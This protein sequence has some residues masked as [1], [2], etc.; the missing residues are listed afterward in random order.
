MDADSDGTLTWAEWS[1]YVGTRRGAL[2]NKL[3]AKLDTSKKGSVEASA[4]IK[5]LEADMSLRALYDM[6]NCSSKTLLAKL[7][8]SGDGIITKEE[9]AAAI[10]ASTK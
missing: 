4:F 6:N 5:A 8:A 2:T 9:L 7:D 10:S 3:F 1:K